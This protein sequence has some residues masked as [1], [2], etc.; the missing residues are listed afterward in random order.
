MNIEDSDIIH[1]LF[2]VLADL[3]VIDVS[4][5][6]DDSG[7]VICKTLRERRDI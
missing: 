7:C 6:N 4:D 3:Y 5:V 1:R 2:F